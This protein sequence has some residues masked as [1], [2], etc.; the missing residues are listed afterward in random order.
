MSRM[1]GN[2]HKRDAQEPFRNHS[3]NLQ[4]VKLLLLLLSQNTLYGPAQGPRP[5][6]TQD[7]SSGLTRQVE[8]VPIRALDFSGERVAVEVLSDSPAR[9]ERFALDR[10]RCWQ[11]CVFLDENSSSSIDV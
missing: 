10:K 4:R 5:V 11:G 9:Q 3:R 1:G 6:T 7:G 8:K 2:A